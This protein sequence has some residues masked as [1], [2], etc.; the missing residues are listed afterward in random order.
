MISNN[1]YRKI[2]GENDK[3]EDYIILDFATKFKEA[4]IKHN[5]LLVA[6]CKNANYQ[7][8]ILKIFSDLFSEK[9]RYEVVSDRNTLFFTIALLLDRGMKVIISSNEVGFVPKAIYSKLDITQ[10]RSNI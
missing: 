3:L 1:E 7:K 2:P 9:I 5:I 6:Y 10:D 8:L 4:V